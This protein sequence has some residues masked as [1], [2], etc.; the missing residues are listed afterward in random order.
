VV[1][2]DI[3][4]LYYA[5]ATRRSAEATWARCSYRGRGKG[6]ESNKPSLSSQLD[7]TTCGCTNGYS[8]LHNRV[9]DRE[10]S[11]ALQYRRRRRG[12]RGGAGYSVGC[13][14]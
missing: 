13:Y 11:Y 1:Y 5:I 10:T 2:E 6:R 9:V 12:G 3:T 8:C 4:S 7:P 14:L